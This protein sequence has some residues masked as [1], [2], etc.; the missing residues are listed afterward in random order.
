MKKN[1]FVEGTIV[2]T[3]AIVL[4]KIMGMLY[5]IPF[6]SIVGTSGG[7]LYSYA[8]NIYLIFLGISSA[9]LPNAIS[10]VISEYNTLGMYDAKTRAMKNAVKIISIISF[11]AF[12]ILFILAEEI[13]TLIIGNLSGGNTIEDV[14]FVIRCVA[15]SVLVIPYLSITKGYLQ[16]HKY[17]TPSST[18]QVIEQIVRIAVI[19]IGSYVILNV[20]KG[21]LRSA[22]GIAV[23]GALFGGIAA[24]IYLRIVMKK[25]KDKILTDITKK[26]DISN[27]EIILKILKYAVPFIIINIVTNIYTFTD[28]ILVLRTLEYLKV[29]ANTV[30]FIA[31]S[32]STWSPKICMVINAIS[33]GMTISLIPTIVSSYTKKDWSDVEDKINKSISMVMFISLPLVLGLMILSVPVWRLFYGY[34]LTG[35]GILRLAVISA[36]FANV[37]MVIS[38]IAQS[39]NKFKTV[40]LVSF[41]GFILNALLDVPIM[42]LF[43]YIGIPAYLGSIVASFI[44][45]TASILIGLISLHVQ[46]K[47]K[48]RQLF[49]NIGKMII[50]VVVMVIVLLIIN[51]FL[52]FSPKSV[53]GSLLIIIINAI[54]GGIIYM[55][56]SYKL[57]LL[58]SILGS[59]YINKIIKKLTKG[60]LKV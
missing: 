38:T 12:L 15:P 43:N 57:G 60:K 28:Q 1:S 7:A 33:M 46:D 29:D 45:Y 3:L 11:I 41:V 32:I 55:T 2:A 37:Y 52:P 4:V 20:F 36:M 26:D 6:Y 30:E 42:L 24:I 49:R 14:A 39:L 16:G 23:M 53:S 17:V 27:K 50:P 48:Y 58:N 8:Y 25:N 19:L 44:G 31:S 10:K 21:E 13:A 40:Y 5:V 22:I 59:E 9:G 18:S 47:I 56:L 51:S 54:I 35:A 34:N